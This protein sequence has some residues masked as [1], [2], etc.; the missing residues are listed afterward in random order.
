M[1]SSA[2]TRLHKI[3]DFFSI[4]TEMLSYPP[5]KNHIEFVE[6]TRPPM[7]SVIVSEVVKFIRN[8]LAHFPFFTTWDDIYFTKQLINWASEGKSIDR[9]LNRYQGH[10]DV[11][12]RFKERESGKWSYSTIRFPKEYNDDK[13]FLKDMINEKDGILLC[14]VLMF[15]VVSSQI[16]KNTYE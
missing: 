13:F 16:I 1:D 10:E 8:I 7:E 11:Q 6:K 4:Y 2:E 14:A 15:G 12:Y 5:I 3:K 9:F